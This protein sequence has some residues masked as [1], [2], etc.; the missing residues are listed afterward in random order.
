MDE[1]MTIGAF[2]ERTGLSVSALRFY[3]SQQVL[4]PAEVDPLNRYRRY[5]EAQVADGCLIRDLRRLGMP[6]DEIVLALAR[7]EPERR[8][9][10]GR[11]LRGLEETVRRAHD[12]ARTM[13]VANR[14]RRTVMT[15]TLQSV[16][17]AGAIDQILPAAGTDPE[18]PH[19]MGVLVE[20]K[21]GSVRL[22]ATDGHRLAIRDLVPFSLDGDFRAIVPAVSLGR[23]R[24]AIGGSGELSLSLDDDLLSVA[25]P[26][27][28]LTASI[29]PI[30]FPD[31]ERF[32]V[33]A[34]E[35]TSVKIDR[36]RLLA[37]LETAEPDSPVRL[38]AIGDRLRLRQG[39]HRAELPAIG[40]GTEQEVIINSS[41]ILDAT[42]DAIGAEVVI[43]IEDPL[44][45]V[46]FR[47][48]DDGTFT[49]RIMPIKLD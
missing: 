34:P 15:A 49:T 7:T 6:L 3:A 43:E 23:W 20:G 41:F 1:L 45:P 24:D 2:A 46:L 35:V 29:I 8:E 12:F 47:S 33:P 17:L 31:Y 28:D 19:L 44:R 21:D 25:G 42:R 5:A 11:H 48:A 9:L 32:L 36:R 27:L 16:E 22:V 30:T 13:G 40:A 37:A 4:V 10:V 38:S 18:R 39:Q 14:T 26:D